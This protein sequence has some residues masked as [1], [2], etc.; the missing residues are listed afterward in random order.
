MANSPATQARKCR[1]S[2]PPAFAAL[3]RVRLAHRQPNAS[4]CSGHL[5]PASALTRAPGEVRSVLMALAGQSDLVWGA[6]HQLGARQFFHQI[7][8]IFFHQGD[9][10]L[11][12]PPAGLKL[13]KLLLADAEL[14]L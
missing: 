14:G 3:L 12:P 11:Q 5:P 8:V 9:A 2:P 4:R 10:M 6:I 1:K 13:G 7:R